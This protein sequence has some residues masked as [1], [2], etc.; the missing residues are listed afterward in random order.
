MSTLQ[1]HP[2]TIA[3]RGAK[4]QTPFNEHNSALFLTSS[5]M[6]ENAETGASLFAG[7]TQGY[8]LSLIHI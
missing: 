3:I 1:L 7:S 5:F 8:T 2:E 6:F 4:E